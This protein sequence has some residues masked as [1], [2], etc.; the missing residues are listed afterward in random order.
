M[1]P[2][3]IRAWI[4]EVPLATLILVCEVLSD[5]LD[6]RNFSHAASRVRDAQADLIQFSLGRRARMQP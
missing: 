6:G 1:E 5:E 3:Q 4:G 2:D